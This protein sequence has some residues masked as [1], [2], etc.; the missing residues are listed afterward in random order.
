MDKII[1]PIECLKGE[2]SLPG[3]KSISHRVVFM[4]SIAKGTTTGENFL[5]A[6][7]CMRTVDAFRKMGINIEIKEKKLSI[8]GKG[9]HGLKKPKE[10]LFLGNSGTTMRVISGIL[11]GQDFEVTLTGD[12]SLSSRPMKRIIEPLSAMGASIASKDDKGFP[13]IKIKQGTLKP[14][15]YK[16]EV[17]SAQVKSSILFAGLYAKGK[18]SVTEPY[19]SRDHTERMLP[20][21]GAKVV[22][23]DLTSTITGGNE[24]KGENIFIPGDISSTSFF[25]AASCILEGSEITIREVGLNPTR[26]GFL[27]VLKRMGADLTIV[28][29]KKKVEPYGTLRVRY[30]KLNPATVEKNEV[31]KLIDEIPILCVV[32]SQV[33]GETRI[34][35]VSE[36]KVKETDRVKA[37]VENMLKLGVDIKTKGEDIIINGK[38][39]RFTASTLQSFGDHRTA[40]SVAIASLKGDGDSTIEN[41]GCVSISF[42]EF[43]EILSYLK[44]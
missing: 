21:F 42:P 32:A 20:A 29:E 16:T 4:G 33:D 31:P 18:T 27:D 36:L 15:E 24:L 37:I 35:G 5:K 38:S 28:P 13:P 44:R 41:V 23:S 30:K 1:K 25:I 40:M 11:V 22:K 6:D 17:A 3:D 10:D 12:E 39:K 19:S 14:I 7:D 8:I 9:L 2:I 43:F 34:K 26:V